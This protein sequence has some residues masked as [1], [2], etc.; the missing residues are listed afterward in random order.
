MEIEN[1]AGGISSELDVLTDALL[2]NAFTICS[3]VGADHVDLHFDELDQGLSTLDDSH[4]Q[5]VT[6]LVLASRS[7]RNDPSLGGRL[8]P[9]CYI[10]TDIWDELSFSDKNKISQSGAVTLEWDSETLLDM[11]NERIKVKLGPKRDWNDL[12]DESLIRGKQS[13]WS[14]IISR[15]FLRPRDV[16]QFLNCALN[17]ALKI[18]P[19]SDFF[20]NDDIQKARTPFFEIP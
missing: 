6:G 8:R 15:T 9:V 3:Q 13:K 14:H 5:M 10:R 1:E 20:D 12:D 2:L 17:V 16:I 11:I 7:V 18:V 4:K 19:A